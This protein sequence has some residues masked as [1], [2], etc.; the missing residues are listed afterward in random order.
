MSLCGSQDDPLKR[1]AGLK[2]LG[3][4]SDGDALQDPMK[5]D[6]ELYTNLIVNGLQDQSQVVREASCFVIGEL[7][8]NLIPDFLD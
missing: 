8:E 6:T 2:I 5:D 3:T 1:K 4:V 7:S